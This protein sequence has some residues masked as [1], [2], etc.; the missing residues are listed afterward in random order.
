VESIPAHK[1]TLPLY[2]WLLTGSKK[3]HASQ[4]HAKLNFSK[5]H[6]TRIDNPHWQ[7]GKSLKIQSKDIIYRKAP[8]MGSDVAVSR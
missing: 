3:E 5:Q 8:A 1:E 7:E 2:I 4:A 6:N